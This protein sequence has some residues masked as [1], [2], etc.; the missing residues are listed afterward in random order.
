MAKGG[1]AKGRASRNSK[2]PTEE[3]PTAGPPSPYV[4]APEELQPFLSTLDPKYVYITH[5]DRHPRQQKLKVYFMT[6]A[7]NFALCFVLIWRAVIVMPWYYSI[8]QVMWDQESPQN[9]KTPETAMTGFL[10]ETVRRTFNFFLDFTLV[11]YTVPWPIDFFFNHGSPTSWRLAIGFRDKENAVRRSRK[12][13]EQLDKDWLAEDASGAVYKDRIMPA[14]DRDWVNSKTSYLMIDK[15]WDLDCVSNIIAQDYVNDGTNKLEDFEKQVIV[16]SDDHGWLV[17]QVWKLD[18]G[19]QDEGREK[20]LQFKKKLIEKGK[21]NLF[22]RWVEVMQFETSQPGGFTE[23]RQAKAMHE[24]SKLFKEEGV[25][26]DALWKE[27]GGRPGD[28]SPGGDEVSK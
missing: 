15:S 21:E 12:W 7:L 26:F 22:Y 4:V 20:I 1:N 6:A 19:E 23:E 5:I 13:H 25:D 8:L 16:H 11:R 2:Q 10:D 24:A 9:V 3:K 18:E 17:W 27:I 28:D 14:I